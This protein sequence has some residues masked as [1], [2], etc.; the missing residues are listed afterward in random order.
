MTAPLRI[1]MLAHNHPDLQPGG[2]ETIARNLFRTLRDTLPGLAGLFLAA[3]T[4][5]QREPKPGTLLQ[6][7]PGGQADEAL[8]WLPHFDRFFLSQADTQGLGMAFGPL[9][10]SL[11]PDIIHIHHP[12]Q[13]GLE[14]IA[15]LRR[16]APRGAKLVMTLHDY[17]AICPR[18]G[19]LLRADGRLCTGPSLDACHHCLPTRPASDLLMRQLAIGQAASLVDAL[20]SPSHFLRDRFVAAGWDAARIT[21]LPNAVDIRG[22]PAPHRALPDG[23]RRDRFGFFGHVNR[24]KGSLLALDA[25]A[26]LSAAGVAH[27]LALHGGAAHQS[28]EFLAEFKAALAAAP[29]ARHHGI[30]DAAELPRRIGAADWVIVPSLWFE[31]A[32]LVV[33]EAFRHGRP[34]I[35]GDAGGM[36]ELVRDG[37]DGL[38][39]PIGDAE[40]WA[41]TMRRAVQEPGLWDRLVQGIRP[42]A[43]LDAMARQHL[44]LYRALLRRPTPARRAPRPAQQRQP[45]AA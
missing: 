5:A 43:G 12:L 24:F 8:M 22:A 30:Y 11:R 7:A 34:V 45:E 39:A 42:P 40:G 25:S 17:F 1:L 38:H 2:T 44:D 26:R 36:A 37:V 6:A 32:P 15:L 3:T 23:G 33:L 4:G 29:A 21:V 9:M 20:V 16:L 31:N 19:Q 14:T 35:C 27:G 13:F 28:S 10:D 18:E 41:A